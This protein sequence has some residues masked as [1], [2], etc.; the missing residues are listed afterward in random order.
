MK[1]IY[2][3]LLAIKEIYLYVAF[4]LTTGGRGFAECA[5]T[6][7]SLLGKNFLGKESLSS[8]FY[9][10]TR[11]NKKQFCRVLGAAL[12]KIFSAVAAPAVNGYFAECP[13]Q[14]SAKKNYFF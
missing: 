9:W 1:Y 3:L 10:G 12:G 5:Y 8:A 13:T 14:H 7:Q 2:M 6:R 11:Q 4:L